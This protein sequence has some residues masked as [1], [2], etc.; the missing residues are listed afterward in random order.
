MLAG[1]VLILFE[2]FG[3]KLFYNEVDPVYLF[4]QGR[5]FLVL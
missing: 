4:L 3:G 2:Y 5:S 1:K